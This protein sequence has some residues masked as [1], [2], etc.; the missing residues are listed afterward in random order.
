MALRLGFRLVTGLREAAADVIVAARADGP[1]TSMA[2]F[3]RRTRLTRPDLERLA[4]AD[5]FGSLALDRREALWHSLAQSRSPAAMPLFATVEEASDCPA[6][7]ALS[8]YEQVIADYRATGLSLKGHPLAFFRKQL[9]TLHVLPA[10]RLATHPDGRRVKVAGIVLLRQRPA[11]ASGITFCSL[12]DETGIA[13]VVVRARVWERFRAVTRASPAWIA[14]GILE[15]KEGVIHI[16][17]G[18]VEDLSKRLG[19][20]RTA[21]RNFR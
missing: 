16:V 20:V 5:A 12:E 14:H 9:D 19:E 1:F 4:D 8:P 13:N 7:P 18:R 21:S 15:R 6:L 3:T 11:T 2:Q 17:L 10:E